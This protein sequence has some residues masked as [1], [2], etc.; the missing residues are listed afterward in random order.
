MICLKNTRHSDTGA[1]LTSAINIAD[2][3]G[4]NA[5]DTLPKRELDRRAARVSDLDITYARRDERTLP[6]AARSC[7]ARME[8]PQHTVLGWRIVSSGG[9]VPST[10]L[11]LHIVGT[12]ANIAEALLIAVAH[13]I[14]EDAGITERALHIND[15]GATESSG[16]FVRDVNLYMRKHIESIAPALRTRASEDPLGTLVQ[17]IERGHPATPRAPQSMEYLNEEERQR[18]W[19]ILEYIE[20]SGFSY[21]LNAHL[22]GS[23]DCWSHT[24]FEISVRD[25]E[26]A[27]R[28][29]LASGGRYDPLVSRIAKTP[30]GGAMISITCETRGNTVYKRPERTVPNIYIAHIGVEARKCILSIIN[31][32]RHAGIMVRHGIW[33]ERM[34]EQMQEAQAIGAPYLLIVGHKEAMDGT[35]LVRTI[36]TN[37]QESVPT[38]ELP[39]YLKRH[40]IALPA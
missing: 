31:V 28:I 17:L 34:G 19:E 40:H 38:A 39:Q 9:A 7:I 23:R 25:P 18:L 6:A 37:I 14:L 3:Y 29:T 8:T 13:A 22:L 10:A 2:W 20:S 21:E 27:A 36:S 33:H 4:F 12:H 24:L 1:L 16:R 5:L 35:V 26:N 11:E 30:V 15:L 32:L